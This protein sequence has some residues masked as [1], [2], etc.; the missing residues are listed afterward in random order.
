[1]AYH[2]VW[3]RP[4]LLLIGSLSPNTCDIKVEPPCRNWDHMMIGSGFRRYRHVHFMRYLYWSNVYVSHSQNFKSFLIQYSFDL[5]L[6]LLRAI[7]SGYVLMHDSSTPL[8]H[9]GDSIFPFARSPAKTWP[10]S[11]WLKNGEYV[12]YWSC[13]ELCAKFLAV[14]NGCSRCQV[15]AKSLSVAL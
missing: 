1:M 2:K 6:C 11:L 10:P 3:S 7:S 9:R 8:R 15:I 4:P 5:C 13:E 14:R 12:F